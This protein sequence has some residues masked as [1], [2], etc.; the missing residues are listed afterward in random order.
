MSWKDLCRSDDWTT[1]ISTPE[2]TSLL[3]QIHHRIKSSFVS[4]ATFDLTWI[5]TACLAVII[6]IFRVLKEFFLLFFLTCCWMHVYP[7]WWGACEAHDAFLLSQEGN[8]SPSRTRWPVVS[9]LLCA[10]WRL[11]AN[12]FSSFFNFNLLKFKFKF[13]WSVVTF[14]FPVKPNWIITDN[15]LERMTLNYYLK[16]AS[17][18]KSKII[19]LFH[20]SP[21]MHYF[22]QINKLR[23]I[24]SGQELLFSQLI[25]EWSRSIRESCRFWVHCVTFAVAHHFLPPACMSHHN[26][27]ATWRQLQKMLSEEGREQGDGGP[28]VSAINN[29]ASQHKKINKKY[30]CT[31]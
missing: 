30:C 23:H 25:C 13:V 26:I 9:W 11:R 12:A 7:L 3:I 31:L 5:L 17:G 20:S 28:L 19:T 8:F 10:C 22:F 1:I 16:H 24:N 6:W 4:S 18:N 14:C 15:Y 29:R 27:T 2:T 21:E